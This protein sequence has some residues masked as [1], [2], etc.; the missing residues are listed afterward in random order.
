M[1]KN[2]VSFVKKNYSYVLKTAG[3]AAVATLAA[4]IGYDPVMQMLPS[5]NA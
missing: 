2:F 5:V 4:K 1:K 3:V